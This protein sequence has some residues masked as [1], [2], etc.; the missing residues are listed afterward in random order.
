MVQRDSFVASLRAVFSV[1]HSHSFDRFSAP[2]LASWTC[3]VVCIHS[4]LHR[5]RQNYVTKLFVSGI[6]QSSTRS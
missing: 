1:I 2:C 6:L 3:D 5:A 4:Q